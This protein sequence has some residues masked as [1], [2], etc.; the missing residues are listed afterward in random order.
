MIER[1][2]SGSDAAVSVMNHSQ[3][4]GSEAVTG[5]NAAAEALLKIKQSV[6]HIMDMNALIASATQQQ[7]HVGQDISQ[8]VEHIADKSNAS[9]QLAQDNQAGS[10]NLKQRAQQLEELVSRF[11]L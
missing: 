6:Q 5:A 4:R 1:L 3:Q 11:T 7:N 10:V 9:A 8:R 2:I